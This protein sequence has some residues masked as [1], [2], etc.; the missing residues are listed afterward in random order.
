M[1]NELIT[2]AAN[3][4]A[5]MDKKELSDI[6]RPLSKQI[7]LFDSF[8]SGT[9]GSEE[10]EIYRKL[11]QGQKLLLQRQEKTFD[12]NAISILTEEGVRIG[13]VPEK[14]NVVFARLMDA[15]KLL[16]AEINNVHFMEKMPVISIGIYMTDY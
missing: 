6:I 14:D 7:H 10:Q 12:S 13:L 9:L 16:T 5:L 15:G 11:K 3:Q 1:K 2:S 4:I 8:V